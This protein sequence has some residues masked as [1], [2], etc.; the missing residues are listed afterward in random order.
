MPKYKYILTA[1]IEVEAPNIIAAE[2]AVQRSSVTGKKLI[3]ATGNFG[4]IVKLFSSREWETPW[5]WVRVL[6]QNLKRKTPNA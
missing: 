2:K 3:G 6:S 4:A 1:E 5:V